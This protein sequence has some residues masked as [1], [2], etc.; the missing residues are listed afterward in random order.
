MLAAAEAA[1]A[2]S[3]PDGVLAA[4]AASR[5]RL[6]LYALLDT[7]E[8]VRQGGRVS[9]FTA[10]VGDLLRIKVDVELTDGQVKPMFKLRTRRKAMEKLAE[11]TQALGPLEHL[12][13]LHA[14]CLDDAQH[15]ADRLAP[16]AP[17][18]PLLVEVSGAVATHVGPN[19]LGVVALTLAP[20]T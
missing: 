9:A 6:K 16:Q 17:Q 8:Y 19:A 12:A 15:L 5:R 11:L 4:V 10:A 1:A 3:S 7:L 18:A 14:H 13:I 2:G 20:T